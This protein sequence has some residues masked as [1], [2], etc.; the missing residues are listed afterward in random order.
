MA[1]KLTEDSYGKSA[2]RLTKVVRNGDFHELFEIEAAVQL[3]GDFEPAYTVGDNR[4]VIATDTIKNTV[5]VLAKENAFTSIEQFAVLLARHFVATYSQVHQAQVQLLQSA[6][7]RIAIDG[8]PHDHAFTSAG[9]HQRSAAATLD[10][11][12]KI[13]IVGGV[14]DLAVLKTTASE[15]RDFH[16]D[17]YRTLKD[18]SDR[19]IATNINAD[20]IFTTDTAEFNAA[21]DAILKAISETF[22]IKHSLGVQQTLVDMGQAALAA[23]PMINS[24]SF[25]LPNMHRIPFNLDPFGLKFD[26]DIYVATDEPY[27]LIK[28]IVTRDSQ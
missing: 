13:S 4:Q 3:Q 15:W 11:G 23:A 10:R 14:R 1:F 27:G 21:N 8:K 22:A 16:T 18:T 12:G 25:E 2:V 9:A 19:I 17:R 5:Y 7:K 6:W 20:W 26:N 28:G 24:I